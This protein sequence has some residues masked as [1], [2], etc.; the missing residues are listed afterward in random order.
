MPDET[1]PTCFVAMPFGTPWDEY[2][3]EI[4]KP[5]IRDAGMSPK[6][7]D[8]IFKAGSILQDIVDQLVRSEVVLV[9]LTEPNRNVHYEL[10][11]AHA[12]GK[13]TVLVA[14]ADASLFFDVG[15]ERLL[16][17]DK[18]RPFWGGEL[19]EAITRALS[20]TLD[21]PASAIPTAFVHIKPTRVEADE[22]L[23]L[24]RR[25]EERISDLF[26]RAMGTRSPVSSLGGKMHSLRDAEALAAKL[27]ETMSEEDV[28]GR[29]IDEGFKPV[30]AE[31]AV[32]RASGN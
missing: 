6:R 13:P 27:L 3:E 2:F 10:G 16:T 24:L 26:S 23:I 20:G 25:I 15:Q 30:M 9:D 14:P 1:D 4:Y 28:H 7:A 21:D 8:D 19:R 12:L 18:D 29:L 31:T 5:A 17:Y 32:A 22:S 11:M